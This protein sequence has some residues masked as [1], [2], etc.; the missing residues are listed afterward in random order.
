MPTTT[1][2]GVSKLKKKKRDIERLLRKP[3]I[4]KNVQIENERALKQLEKQINAASESK[5]IGKV[6]K[7]YH[8]VKFFERRKAMRKVDKFKRLLESNK[9]KETLKQLKRAELE[10]Y[11]T[12]HYP[13]GEKYISLYAEQPI[14][15]SKQI[16]ILEAMKKEIE[17]SST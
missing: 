4:A 16:E 12:T 8:K 6:E 17:I 1:H 2:L 9:D 13:K 14:P 3:D 7:A 5:R 15:N 10:L 11:Y